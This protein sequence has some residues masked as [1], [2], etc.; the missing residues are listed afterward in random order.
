M[1]NIKAGELPI[2]AIRHLKKKD[3]DIN[4]N[5]AVQVRFQNGEDIQVRKGA[6]ELLYISKDRDGF[7]ANVQWSMFR[8]FAK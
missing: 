2:R 7:P 4:P 5:A 3:K 1:A 6:T 8:Q